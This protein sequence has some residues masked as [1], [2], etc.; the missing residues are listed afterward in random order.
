MP[1]TFEYLARIYEAEGKIDS[2]C[3]YYKKA[4][5]EG[6]KNITIQGCR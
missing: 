4:K 5:Q 3:Y 2:A 1:E 6:A